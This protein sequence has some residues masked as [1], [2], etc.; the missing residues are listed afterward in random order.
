[1]V[2]NRT[3]CQFCPKWLIKSKQY[4]I[5]IINLSCYVFLEV[6]VS[7]AIKI[8][9]KC[10]YSKSL[11]YLKKT[12][13]NTFNSWQQ[14]SYIRSFWCHKYV[15]FYPIRMSLVYLFTKTKRKKN[16][17]NWLKTQKNLEPCDEQ[18]NTYKSYRTLWD[19]DLWLKFLSFHKIFDKATLTRWKK[20]GEKVSELVHG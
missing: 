13:C 3:D 17:S 10:H 1:M 15:N 19:S 16:H 18:F 9:Q 2:L 14:E 12:L 5:N 4:L 11:S 20:S 7:I 6:E 8:Y